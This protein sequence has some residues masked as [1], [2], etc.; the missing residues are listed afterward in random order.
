M[1]PMGLLFENSYLANNFWTVS[2]SFDISHEYSL[3]QGLSVGTNILTLWSWPW[4]LAC[5]VN[6]Y[7]ASI[8]NLLI[9]SEWKSFRLHMYIP[10]EKLFLLV[11][12]ILPLTFDIFLRE[13]NVI[14]NK[15]K[16]NIRAFILHMSIY[17]DRIMVLVHVNLAIL[18][19]G[20]YRGYLCV[21]NT[22]C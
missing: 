14:H 21:K 19:I 13:M 5:F 20:I 7:L 11:L 17:C 3:W 15:K 8:C 22:S 12:K 16:I 4:S 2:A 18:G 10:C 6:F 9:I 1:W